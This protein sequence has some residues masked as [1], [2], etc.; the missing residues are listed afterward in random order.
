VVVRMVLNASWS[1]YDALRVDR[2]LQADEQEW[3]TRCIAI[4]KAVQDGG[5]SSY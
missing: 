3:I 2:A 4:S 1:V 5:A